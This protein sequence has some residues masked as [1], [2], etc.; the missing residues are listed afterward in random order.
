[1]YPRNAAAPER[2]AVG[3]VVQISDG[4]VQTSGV[5]ITVRKQS[6]A[7]SAGGGTVDIG[8]N[9]TVYYT[10]TQAETDATSFTVEAFKAGC[11]PRSITIVTS[12]DSTPGKVSLAGTQTA[13]IT[14]NLTGNVTGSI[15]SLGAQAKADV[16]AECDTAI[17]DYDAPTKAEL[18]AAQ[19]AIVS[20]CATA[21]GFATP[22]DAM[23][24][25]AGER[26][27]LAAAIEA[28]IINELDGTAVMQAIADLIADDMTTGDLSVQAIAAAVRDAILDRVLAGNHDTAGTPGKLLQDTF[29]N[30]TEIGTPP[31]VLEIRTELDSNSVR[32]AE[33]SIGMARA[34][35]GVANVAKILNRR[36]HVPATLSSNAGFDPDQWQNDTSVSEG[37]S[38]V[39]RTFWQNGNLNRV[40][41]A[42]HLVQVKLQTAAVH[43]FGV[44]AKIKVFR[45]GAV[46]SE[47]EWFDLIDTAATSQTVDL[48]TPLEVAVGDSIG[49][50]LSDAGSGDASGLAL[51]NDPGQSVKYVDGD[52][53]T[54]A[55]SAT[56]ANYSLNFSALSV[57][58][59]LAVTGDS[60]AEGHNGSTDYH[61]FLHAG[62]APGGNESSE[63]AYA[64]KRILGDEFSYENHALGSQTFQWV[65]STGVPSSLSS[66]AR[67]IWIHCGVNDVAQGR[68]WA[69]VEDDLNAIRQL[70]PV[71]TQCYLSE[72]LPWTAGSDAQAA[73]IR[74]W[75]SNLST[76]CDANGVTL[77][78]CHDAMG[79]VRGT[80]GEIDDLA[81]SYNQDGVHLTESGVLALAAIVAAEID[82]DSR[83]STLSGTV[84][85]V[86]KVSTKVDSALEEDGEGGFQLT[87]RSLEHAPAGSGG[88]GGDYP[89]P[90]EVATAV[91]DALP[92]EAFQIVRQGP[93]YDPATKTI[94]LTRAKDYR[95]IH[96]QSVTFDLPTITGIDWS[97]E[98]VTLVF[99]GATIGRKRIGAIATKVF[100]NDTHRVRL[101]FPR[102]MIDGREG[103]Y[104]W[105]LDAHIDSGSRVDVVEVFK[106]RIRLDKSAGQAVSP[107]VD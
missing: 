103:D 27:S 69:A 47:S 81:T 21:T 78:R 12:A 88:G 22:G 80:T 68:T 19:T 31:S 86:E 57:V 5:S 11:L 59:R 100:E 13:N 39:G 52:V 56:L 70:I 107:A 62:N 50:Y 96:G 83:F 9:G 72:V 60:I 76:W 92:D 93:D 99:S 58:P 102:E 37:A 94:A 106:G 40:R 65:R 74:D 84:S 24:L 89:T 77:I 48:A 14:G 25:T 105:C 53:T 7:E 15:G 30:S 6:G 3:A 104:Q 17:A 36:G 18:D 67:S 33:L 10:P 87:E 20:A 1:M 63:I 90:E 98:T 2:V 16:N 35:D 61:G 64:V 91:V 43:D 45:S 49:I 66:G 73:T 42:G 71:S 55:V 54:D 32:L 23:T 101:E 29:A 97:S 41:R 34:E 82:F 44:P 75:N 85:A 51:T 95:S 8:S 46:V 79:Q 28:A 38:G 4:A 26:T